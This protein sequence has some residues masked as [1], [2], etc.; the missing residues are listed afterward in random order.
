LLEQALE[1]VLVEPGRPN[2]GSAVA[3]P[4]PPGDD[5]ESTAVTDA[6]GK[7]RRTLVPVVLERRG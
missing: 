5:G 1:A 7:A 3:Q 2:D 6:T 4:A